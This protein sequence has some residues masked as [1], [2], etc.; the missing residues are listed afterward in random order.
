MDAVTHLG[1]EHLV[2]EPVLGYTAQT[3][4]R[5]RGYDGSEVMPVA[6]YLRGGAGN[7]GLDPLLQLLGSNRHSPSVA[8]WT[9]GYTE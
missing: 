9:R 2:H 1:A 8:F 5:G 3:L 6:R 4:E 7:S